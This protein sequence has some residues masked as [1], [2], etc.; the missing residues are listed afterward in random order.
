MQIILVSTPIHDHAFLDLSVRL[1]KDDP[2]W[3]QPLNKDIV[4]IFDPKINKEFR[5]G[6]AQRWLLMSNNGVVIGRIAAFYSKK[7]LEKDNPQ[8]TGGMGFFECI[9]SQEAAN[10]LF[11]TAKDWLQSKGMQAMDGPINFGQRDQWWGLLVEG[12]YEPNYCSNY[13]L[14]YYKALFETYGF[15]DYFQQFTYHV[16]VKDK[17]KPKVK[18]KGARVLADP[19]YTFRHLEPQNIAQHAEEFR[20][21]YN[22][23][24]VKH[25]GVGE[26]RKEQA[27][28]IMKKIKPIMDP[29]IIWFGYYK[30]EPIAFFIMLPEVNQIFKHMKGKFG[31]VEKLKF[32]WHKWRKTCKKMFGVVFGVVP[33][34]QGRGVECAIVLAFAPHALRKGFQYTELELNWIGDFNPKMLRVSEDVGG[35]IKKIHITYRYLFDREKPFVRMAA[36]K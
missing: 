7:E 35:E 19:D 21:I 36:I 15:Q 2:N 34:F 13:H 6:E 26:M 27:M 18:E 20:T 4:G 3:I 14:P 1:Y 33:D 10:L 22:K 5:N 28:L 29:E 24:W 9:N 30:G 25:K 16:A 31:M 23:A 8:P 17:L 12:F 32:M 11:D